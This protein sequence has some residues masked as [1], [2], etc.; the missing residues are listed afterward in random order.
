[1]RIKVQEFFERGRGPAILAGI[2]LGDGFFEEGRLLAKAYVNPLRVARCRFLFRLEMGFLV[3]S[4]A[5]NLT[6]SYAGQILA[7]GRFA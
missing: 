5:Y 1:M 6:R 4:H 7:G 2:H 3:C